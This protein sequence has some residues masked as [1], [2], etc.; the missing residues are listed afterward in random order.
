MDDGRL[1]AP[2]MMR[3]ASNPSMTTGTLW[4]RAVAALLLTCCTVLTS[5]REQRGTTAGTSL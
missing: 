3:W 2:R 5:V 4:R 1:L